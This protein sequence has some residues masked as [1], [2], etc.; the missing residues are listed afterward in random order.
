MVIYIYN[1]RLTG[2]VFSLVTE[3]LGELGFVQVA[4]AVQVGVQDELVD[5][6]IADLDV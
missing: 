1:N 5:V 3:L 2:K 6:G 4:V